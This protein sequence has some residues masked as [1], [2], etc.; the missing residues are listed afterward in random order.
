MPRKSLSTRERLRLFT[1]HKGICHICEGRIDGAREA[2]EISHE[3][4]L[5]LG[6]ADDDE[7]RKPA[8]YKC[9]RALT[10]EQDIPRIAKAKRREARHLGAKAPSSRPIPGSKASG[11]RKRMD[12]RV[13]RR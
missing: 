10:A 4:P 13:E 8:H 3:L 1:L 5:E 9:H 7:N 11:W 12:G 2:W 6:G